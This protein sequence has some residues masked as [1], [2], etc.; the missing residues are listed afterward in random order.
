MSSILLR[1]HGDSTL[2]APT[3]H[4]RIQVEETRME[5]VRW[6]RK[7]WVAIRSESGFDNLETW[8]IQ[9]ISHGEVLSH[10]PTNI[11]R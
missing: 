1:P 4:I 10:L 2:L 11:R 5:V 9:E 3:S 6:M 7:R 8:A